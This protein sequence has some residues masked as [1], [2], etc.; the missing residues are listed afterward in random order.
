MST[1]PLSRTALLTTAFGRLIAGV[2]FIGGMVFIP[3]GTFRYWQAWLWL[4]VLLLPIAVLGVVLAF[5]DPELLERR[6]RTGERER[7]Q[8]IVITAFVAVLIV[9]FIVPGLDR[10]WGWSTVPT[11]VVLLSDLLILAGFALF[12]LTI[13]ENRY[14]SRVIEVQDHQ[15]VIASGPYALIRHPMYLAMTLV[16]GFSPLALGSWWG[17]IPCLLIPILLA[18][19]IRHEE[20]MLRKGLPGYEEYTR[21]VR[22]RLVPFLW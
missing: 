5:Q 9:A 6:M 15:P 17:A 1:Q 11:A 8:Q 16:L 3:A 22:H 7:P 14:A 4:T 19:R 10:R 13:R 2:V 20:E 18:A 12:I 21:R